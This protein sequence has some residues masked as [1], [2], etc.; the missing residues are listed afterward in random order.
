[1]GAVKILLILHH[2]TKFRKKIGQ[3]VPEIS[4]F[5]W[6]SRWRPPPS[7][8]FANLIFYGRR[9][10]RG[11]YASSCQISSKSV[12]PLQRY[13]ELTVFK[14]AAVRHLGFVA[15]DRDHPR[16]LLGGLYRY[17]KFGW[18]RWISFY[19]MTL[20]IF[21]PFGLKTPIHAPKMV[22][23]GGGGFHPQNGEQYQRNPQEADPCASPRRFEPSSVKIRR[24]VWPVREF[25]K[26]GINK[27]TI[28]VSHPSL[29]SPINFI[30]EF[31][32]IDSVAQSLCIYWTFYV[33][34]S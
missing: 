7:W 17:A 26:K 25:A 15:R 20:S 31:Y 3:T 6:F 18:N 22:F 23:F 14:M 27:Q 32:P 13:G 12:K 30:I 34:S 10:E 11:Q 8:I 24:P 28:V 33:P 29:Y 5:L 1:M 19:N 4:W 16:W 9:A 21:C 2:Q